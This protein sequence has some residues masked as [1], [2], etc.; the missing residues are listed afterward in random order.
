MQLPVK[1]DHLSPRQ[2][3]IVRERYVE[4]QDG[5]CYW[6]RA[7]LSG[8]PSLNARAKPVAA[9]LFP[10]NFFKYPVHLQHNHRTGM[11]EGAVHAHCNAVMWQYHG[12]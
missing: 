12:R 6:C 1:Y 9:K 3:R 5:L 2:R 4:L 10:P 8:K 7:P 11:T